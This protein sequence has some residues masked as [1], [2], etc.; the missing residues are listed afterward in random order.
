MASVLI[1]TA[2]MLLAQ[3]VILPALYVK[4]A[5][6]GSGTTALPDGASTRHA[7]SITAMSVTTLG[8]LFATGA[9][10]VIFSTIMSAGP[11]HVTMVSGST[12]LLD[13]VLIPFARLTT[14]S[15]VSRAALTNVTLV[16]LGT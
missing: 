15:T 16:K 6:P 2:M 11:R 1:Q 4:S 13:A 10:K 5:P 3:N 8:Q 7:L 14:A 9:T 12:S